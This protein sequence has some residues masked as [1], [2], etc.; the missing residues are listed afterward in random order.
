MPDAVAAYTFIRFQQQA[1]RAETLAREADEATKLAQQT[2]N[3]AA[4]TV[5]EAAP[6]TAA[7]RKLEL[8]G[9]RADAALAVAE[10]ALA[11]AKTE[12]VC[13]VV[14]GRNDIM[15]VLMR[16]PGRVFGGCGTA[17]IIAHSAFTFSLPR[18]RNWRRPFWPP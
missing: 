13:L 18:K 12:P 8:A 4:L 2:K 3:A 11:A 16:R 14:A 7:L 5:K 15:E 1:A 17:Q 6:L 9:T 10:K